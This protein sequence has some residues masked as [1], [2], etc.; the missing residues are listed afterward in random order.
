MVDSSN[1][2]QGVLIDLDF[3]ARVAEHGNPLNG[4][5]FPPAGTINFRAFDVLT[6]HKPAKAYYRHD[7]ESFFYVLLWIQMHYMNGKKLET[8]WTNSFDFDFDGTWSTTQ[9]RKEGFFLSGCRR[10]GYQ[11]PPT[12]LRDQWLAPMRRLFGE[13]LW[14]ESDAISLHREGKGPLLDPDTFGERITYEAFAKILQR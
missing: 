12:L 4:E 13:A 14:A 5:T 9:G 7:L 2:S 1:P 6:P 11:L 3:A 8:P 10:D